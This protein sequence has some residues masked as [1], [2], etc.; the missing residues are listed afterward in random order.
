MKLQ[1][2]SKFAVLV[3][4]FSSSSVVSAQSPTPSPSPIPITV[5]RAWLEGNQKRSDAGFGDRLVVEVEHLSEAMKQDKINPRDFVLFMDGQAMKGVKVTGI[6]GPKPRDNDPNG[7]S[8]L[9]FDLVRTE[10]SDAAWRNLLGSPKWRHNYREVG[11]SVG[12]A[13]GEAIPQ[14]TPAYRPVMYLRIYHRWWAVGSVVGLLLLVAGFVVLARMGH[15]IRDTNPPRAAKKNLKP[16]SLALTQAAWWFFLVIGSFVFIYMITGD[17]NSMTEQALI[18]MG[19]GTGTALGSFMVNASKRD[20][21]DTKLSTLKPER[22]KLA[23]EIAE[24]SAAGGNAIALQEKQAKLAEL[25]LQIADAESG[26]S[27]SAWSSCSASTEILLCPH[28][29]RRCWP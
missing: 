3:V 22:A 15:V 8:W 23:A 14:S 10:D 4:L 5:T 20:S 26:L 2:L 6:E 28:S 9:A 11:V 24:L 18:L 25:D 19:I 1:T 17:Y 7:P 12:G 21:A 27:F 13:D 29:A 16:Y